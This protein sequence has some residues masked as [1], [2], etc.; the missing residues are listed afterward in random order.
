MIL[1]AS[2]RA[3]TNLVVDKTT[4]NLV[5]LTFIDNALK[6]TG[7]VIQRA[8]NDAFTQNVQNMNAPTNAGSVGT[9]IDNTVAPK[10]TYYYR[11]SA[12]LPSGN[13]AWSN[14]VTTQTK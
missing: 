2:A 14:V 10:T 3:P 12:V 11:I 5:S 4:R 1:C 8:T 9:F 13:T 7:F 6:E